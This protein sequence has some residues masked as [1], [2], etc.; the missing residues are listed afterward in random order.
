MN[1]VFLSICLFSLLFLSVFEGKSFVNDNS[2]GGNEVILPLQDESYTQTP[3]NS[4]GRI[5]LKENMV[6]GINLLTQTMLCQ[7]NTIYVI[8]Y[9]FDLNYNSL[10]D[11]TVP[12][13]CSLLFEGGSINNGTIIGQD[14]EIQA[15]LVKVFNTNVNLAGSWRNNG[16][17]R[18]FGANP[19][20]SDNTAAIQKCLDCFEVV[21]I[22][23]ATYRTDGLCMT[24]CRVM[25]GVKAPRGETSTLSFTFRGKEKTGLKVMYNSSYPYVEIEGVSFILKGKEKKVTGSIAIDLSTS[26][27]AGPEQYTVPIK[28]NGCRFDNFEVGIK[29]NYRSYY[30][31]IDNCV[32][33]NVS[34]CLSC[35]SSNNL[36]V[37]KT[38]AAYFSHFAYG[39]VGNG[40][41][42]LRDCSFELYTGSVVFTNV[43]DIGVFNFMNNYVETVQGNILQGFCS[44]LVSIGNSIQVDNDVD[45]LYYPYNIVSFISIGNIIVNRDGFRVNSTTG[46]YD[47]KYFKYYNTRGGELKSFTSRDVVS[48]NKNFDIK[49]Y[50]GGHI[51]LLDGNRVSVIGYEPFTGDMLTK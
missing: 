38:Y 44:S 39:V 6:N 25:K 48:T 28:C 40:P 13:N 8:R 21:D 4:Q 31:F 1:K 5:V 23:N 33:N 24:K 15:G 30:N 42:T 34:R 47:F 32:F 26:T 11:V 29:S 51:P 9:D 10:G 18:W 41:F 20:I 49:K 14:T 22:D 16:N 45:C 7:E 37:N 46:K 2:F 35:F 50:T 3:D 43:G 19:N 12:A 27:S 36:I 17:I